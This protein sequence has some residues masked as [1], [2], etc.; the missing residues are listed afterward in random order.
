MTTRV[1]IICIAIL[2]TL[3]LAARVAEAQVWCDPCNRVLLPIAFG[4]ASE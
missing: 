2:L 3:L 1:I 4:D